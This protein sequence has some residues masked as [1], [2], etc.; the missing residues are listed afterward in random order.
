MSRMILYS[1][2]VSLTTVLAIGCGDKKT[3]PT[4]PTP[5]E[6]P[7]PTPTPT[8]TPAPAPVKAE[9]QLVADPNPVPF[10]GTPITDAAGCANIKNTW[11][12][13]HVFTEINGTQVKFTSRVD[14]FDGRVINNITGLDM[15]VPAKGTLRIKARWCSSN[16]VG[17]EAQTSFTGTDANGNEITLSGPMVRLLAPGG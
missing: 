5:V 15:V 9:V 17:H 4:S 13:E 12:Y 8:P 7:A 6:T 2:V 11:Y 14:S 16:G 1:A 10:S 3:P